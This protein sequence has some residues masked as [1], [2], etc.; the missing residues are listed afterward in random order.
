MGVLRVD[1]LVGHVLSLGRYHLLPEGGAATA[2]MA[3][4]PSGG[5]A[6]PAGEGFAGVSLVLPHRSALF[7]ADP[8]ALA[9]AQ[10]MNRYVR[11]I[12]EG[13]KLAGIP[14]F[15]PGL[16]AI[17]V[18]GRTLGLVSFEVD[19]HGALLFE[20][21]LAIGEDFSAL[22][23]LLETLDPSGTVA[24]RLMTADETTSFARELGRAPALD[25]VAAWM[26]SGYEERLGLRCV[27]RTLDVPALADVEERAWLES[28]RRRPALAR[29][30]SVASLLG[31][32][33]AHFGLAQGRVEDIVFSGDFLADSA[34]IVRLEDELRGCAGER[35][36]LE[37]VVHGVF[38]DPAHFILGIGPVT[39]LSDAIL[40]G[41]PS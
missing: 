37:R 29:R 14:A 33:E 13:C 1:E 12:L 21:I 32:L 20:S 10:V 6:V 9:P 17:T 30:G 25:E 23:A 15:Y 34:A 27:E 41:L 3:R 35:V 7:A 19:A 38:A 4:R 36:A 2:A 26:R 39:T 18:G 5:R 24:A 8:F 16:D 22:P 28:R 40:R 31:V 11:G